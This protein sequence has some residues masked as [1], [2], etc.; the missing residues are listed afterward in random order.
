MM[1]KNFP[2]ALMLSRI[3]VA[4]APNMHTLTLKR[5]EENTSLK[6]QAAGLLAITFLR[7]YNRCCFS[8]ATLFSLNYCDK[9]V[10]SEGK[11]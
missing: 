2:V 4:H 6:Q 7:T 3:V 9:L 1:N 5:T 8:F 11:Y 10:H